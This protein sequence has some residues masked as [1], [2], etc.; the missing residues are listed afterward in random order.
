M[1]LN[2]KQ[3]DFMHALLFLNERKTR[4]CTVISF[5]G[6]SRATTGILRMQVRY[7]TDRKPLSCNG[8]TRRTTDA[9]TFFRPITCVANCRTDYLTTAKT[10]MTRWCTVAE[11][12]LMKSDDGSQITD[13]NPR[14]RH[15]IRNFRVIWRAIEIER[16]RGISC[17]IRYSF[18]GIAN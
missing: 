9:E 8:H 15:G 4:F 12:I 5:N 7:R 11:V 2:I 3:L 13:W 1:P 6:L 16:S 17:E 14:L 10:V 18:L